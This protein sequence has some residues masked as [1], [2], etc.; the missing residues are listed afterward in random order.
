MPQVPEVAEPFDSGDA[1][2]VRVERVQ[3]WAE[4]QLQQAEKER[5]HHQ[6]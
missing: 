1:V 5:Y 6:L 4:R 2:T 3:V